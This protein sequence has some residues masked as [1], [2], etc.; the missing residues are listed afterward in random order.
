MLPLN[1]QEQYRQRYA[2][3][4]PG[5]R[6]SGA[7]YETMIR[8]YL[9][10]D[11]DGSDV[12]DKA[13]LDL[14]CGAGGVIELFS[15]QLRL[16]VG[17]DRDEASLQRHRAPAVRLVA[18][19]LERLPFPVETFD[20]V[21]SSW[22]LEHLHDPQAVFEEVA[23]ILRPRGH[24]VFLT[25]N[26]R[27]GIARINRLAPHVAQARLVSMLYGRAETDTFPT[28]YRINTIAGI[29]ALASS[30]GLQPVTLQTVSDPTYL[31]F[32]DL[33]FRLS[34]LAARHIPARYA[35]HIVGDFIRDLTALQNPSALVH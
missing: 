17:I 34:A 15:E 24:F 6:W 11:D 27:S 9:Q 7:L 16:P 4:N 5:W 32:N 13:L 29:A 30:V 8:R 18:G 33:L 22:T 35:E 14:G 26:A 3:A 21:I 31:A 12:A 25:P 23:R 28:A 19:S 10:P 2:A 20:L 1:H